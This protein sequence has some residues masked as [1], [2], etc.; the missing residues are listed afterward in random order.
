MS[1]NATVVT[2]MDMLQL[3]AGPDYIDPIS[4]DYNCINSPRDWPIGIIM[5]FMV[6]AIHVTCLAIRHLVANL[7]N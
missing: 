6:I 4:R 1:Y 3:T 2:S 7:T 5:V